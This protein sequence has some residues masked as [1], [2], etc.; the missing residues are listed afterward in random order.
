MIIE[1]GNPSAGA[2]T[3]IASSSQ[4]AVPLAEKS[5]K[6]SRANFKGWQKRVFFWLTTLGMKKFTSEDRLALTADMPDHEKFMIFKAWKQIDFLC[7]CYFL[8]AL[9]DDLYNVYSAMNTSKELWDALEKK[10]KTEDA[11]LKIFVVATFL[12]YKMIDS[13]TVGTQV[14]E[15]QLI[16]HDLI[17]NF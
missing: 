16:F 7:K 8:S 9:E 14:Q 12:N 6:F 10:Y 11:C 2:A 17:A 3:T 4:T 13:K 5:G 15:V 1:N